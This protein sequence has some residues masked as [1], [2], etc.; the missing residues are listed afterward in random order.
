MIIQSQGG[1]YEKDY[2]KVQ[3]TEMVAVRAQFDP[4]TGVTYG[5]GNEII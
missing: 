3:G 4:F 2:T 5:Y 1:Y